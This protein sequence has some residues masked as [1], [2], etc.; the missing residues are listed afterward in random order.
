MLSS[1]IASNATL[2]EFE[3]LTWKSGRLETRN[4]K[5][6]SQVG[7]FF[8][9]LGSK[10]DDKRMTLNFSSKGLCFWSASLGS[11]IFR[12]SMWKIIARARR[13]IQS[14]SFQI[15]CFLNHLQC[16]VFKKS[17]RAFSQNLFAFTSVENQIILNNPCYYY[18]NERVGGKTFCLPISH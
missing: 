6:T 2:Q 10:F 5:P 17:R 13:T 7:G 4:L 15:S 3:L 18:Y 9:F 1:A 16:L 8:L 11:Q 12:E 14:E